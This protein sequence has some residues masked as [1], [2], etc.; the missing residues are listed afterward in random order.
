[1]S[2]D[3]RSGLKISEQFHH[4]GCGVAQHPFGFGSEVLHI[5]DLDN[6]WSG[7]PVEIAAMW[8]KCLA[9]HL[10][11]SAMLDAILVALHQF[12]GQPGIDR[13]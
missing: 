2:P 8:Q 4:G 12:V 6:R 3:G 13:G 9:N 7:S 1:M 11:R 10:D 5:G